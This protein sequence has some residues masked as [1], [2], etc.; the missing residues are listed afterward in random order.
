MVDIDWGALG[1]PYDGGYQLVDH[2]GGQRF[3]WHG[4]RNYVELAPWGLDAHIFSV[5]SHA[6]IL[7]TSDAVTTSDAGVP[8]GA[9]HAR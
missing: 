7:T 3:D 8:A 5:R 1:L 2:L 6:H 9:D 4:A